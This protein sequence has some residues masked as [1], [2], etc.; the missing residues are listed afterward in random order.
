[1]LLCSAPGGKVWYGQLQLLF[2]YEDAD[3]HDIDAAFVR[4]FVAVRARP[5]HAT[6]FKLQPLKWEVKGSG[7]SAGPRADVITLDQIIGPCYVQ[8]DP[9][10]PAVFYYNH[11]IGNTT[12]DA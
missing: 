11:W 2:S 6:G 7:R 10:D 3:G 1:M 8:Q 12:N 9:R 4:W 5:R